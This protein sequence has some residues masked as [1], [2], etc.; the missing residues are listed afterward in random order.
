TEN[1]F[2]HTN[3]NATIYDNNIYYNY[4]NTPTNDAN[5]ITEDPKVMNPGSAPTAAAKI[6]A[7]EITESIVH[8]RTAFEGYM[9]ADDSPAIAA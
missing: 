1:W 5:A 4:A 3:A 8:E 2:K 9:L 6:T 7:G